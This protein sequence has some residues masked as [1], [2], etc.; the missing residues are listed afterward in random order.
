MY[1]LMHTSLKTANA[2][3]IILSIAWVHYMTADLLKNNILVN[4]VNDNTKGLLIYD[5]RYGL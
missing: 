3:S 2:H 1:Y 5:E 4:L